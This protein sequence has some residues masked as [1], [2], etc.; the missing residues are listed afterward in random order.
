MGPTGKQYQRPEPHFRP[1]RV[2]AP[3]AEP[4]SNNDAFEATLATAM[5][6][7]RE[8]KLGEAEAIY[9]QALEA[10]PD[11]S[12]LLH[13]LGLIAYQRGDSAAAVDLIGKAIARDPNHANPHA[14]LGMALAHLGKLD[15]AVAAYRKAIALD[16]DHAAAAHINLGL[17]VKGCDIHVHGRSV[18]DCNSL[19]IS[20]LIQFEC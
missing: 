5:R 1:R 16:P 18:E 9:R 7:H 15:A 20:I 11:R 4:A 14:N 10:K 19:F 8:G 13:H 3:A 2:S 17:G 6:F 12:D